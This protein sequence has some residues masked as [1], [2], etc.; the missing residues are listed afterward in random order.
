MVEF[1]Q[2]SFLGLPIFLG[3]DKWKVSSEQFSTS[4]RSYLVWGEVSTPVRIPCWYSANK[5]T[6]YSINLTGSMLFFGKKM[7]LVLVV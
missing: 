5:G 2:L 1:L 7:L 6:K 3:A 4:L